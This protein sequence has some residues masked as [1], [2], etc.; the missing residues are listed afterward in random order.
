MPGGSREL[1]PL[2]AVSRAT[3]KRQRSAELYRRGSDHLRGLKGAL[4]GLPEGCAVNSRFLEFCELSPM[5]GQAF[6]E[7][8]VLESFLFL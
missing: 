1:S 2:E 8:A 6:G 7:T 4:V 3:R 5:L